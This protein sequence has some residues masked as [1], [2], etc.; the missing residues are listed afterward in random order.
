MSVYYPQCRA[1]LKV[2]FDSFGDD[3]Q[4]FGGDAQHPTVIHVLPKS[5]S[6]H[7]NGY[8]QADTFELEFDA[9]AFPFSPE[10]VR[11]IGVEIYMFQ[12]QGLTEHVDNFATDNAEAFEK[13][14][15]TV[16]GLSAS[17][18][19]CAGIVDDISLHA[20]QDGMSFH[21]SGRDYTGLMLDKAWRPVAG[22]NAFGTHVPASGQGGRVPVGKPLDKVIQDLV[23]EA[24][25]VFDPKT[26]KVI[27]GETLTV[28]YI[29][30]GD[31][32]TGKLSKT[33]TGTETIKKTT[34]S[35]HSR[36]NKRGIPVRSGK[37]YWDVIYSTCLAHGLIAFVQGNEVIISSP[38]VLTDA[39]V[40]RT[41]VMIYGRNLASLDIDRHI[42]REQVPQIIVTSYNEN[43]SQPLIAKWPPDGKLHAVI[44]PSF[45]SKGHAAASSATTGLGTLKEST[46]TYTFP[47]ITDVG[48]LTEIATTIYQNLGR[49]ESKV[50]FATIDLKDLQGHDLTQLRAGDPV[51]LGFDEININDLRQLTAAEREKRLRSL[52]YSALVSRLIASEF[53]KLNQF[54]APYYVKD[55]TL[56]WDNS[57]GLSI[58]CEAIK[59]V[60]IP[61]D[62]QK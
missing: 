54:K 17:N 33:A 46:K 38:Q 49:A 36:T 11:A 59:F 23:N 32:K 6:V 13:P 61:R 20:G 14:L 53:D 9:K 52:G 55:V 62:D 31:I 10:I 41:R 4:Q 22:Q 16:S 5:S 27:S 25:Q 24:V 18:L 42:G 43:T 8:R 26:H 21:A 7:L 19:V 29:G 57:T 50:K 35:K 28:R 56:S 12:T 15:H 1:I 3:S 40:D 34:G 60:C 30:A 48:Q 39:T 44:D 58:D 2:V 37:N 47:G 45:K 51:L